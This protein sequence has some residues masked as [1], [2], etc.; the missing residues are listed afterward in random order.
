MKARNPSTG[1]LETVYVKALDSLPV[2]SEIDFIGSSSDI[3]VGW[4]QVDDYSTTEVNTGKTWIDGKPIYRIVVD[5][6]TPSTESGVI[7]DYTSLNVGVFTKIEGVITTSYDII[8]INY[9]VGAS[10]YSVVYLSPSTKKVTMVVANSN[11]RNKPVRLI[12]EYT[13]AS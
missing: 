4:E 7:Y 10:N 2:G 11:M 12:L 13:K 5:T 6:N 8:N 3:P 1:N 9:Y